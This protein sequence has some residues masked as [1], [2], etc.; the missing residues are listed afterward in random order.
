MNQKEKT[1]LAWDIVNLVNKKHCNNK[2][3]ISKITFFKRKRTY[4]GC[5]NA[6]SKEIK[7]W[8]RVSILQLYYT[9]IHELA[10]ACEFQ[11]NKKYWNWKCNKYYHK[12]LSKRK[13]Y[14]LFH[15]RRFWKT[16]STL[17]RIVSKHID[18]NIGKEDKN[19]RT[20]Y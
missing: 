18:I 15:S 20:D 7:L 4:Y 1:K 12:D 19:V 10:H 5:Y 13:H 14:E 17:T 9:T 16:Y 6:N 8:N 11:F 3:V 2:L